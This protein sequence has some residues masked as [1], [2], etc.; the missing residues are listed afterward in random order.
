MI[1]FAKKSRL[2]NLKIFFIVLRCRKRISKGIVLL[3]YLRLGKELRFVLE[4]LLKMMLCGR[5]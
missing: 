5:L 1:N 3:G 4:L 2:Q